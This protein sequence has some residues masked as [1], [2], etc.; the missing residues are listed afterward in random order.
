MERS[1]FLKSAFFITFSIIICKVI[2]LLYVIP[3][4]AMIG[5][6]GGALYSY[7]YSIYAVFLSLSTSG[8]P[9]AISKLISEYQALGYE[10]TKER[11]YKLGLLAIF[12]ISMFL[13]F[14][15][16]LSAPMLA[17]IIL[18]GT[19]GG[20]SVASVTTVIRIVST[21][22]WLVPLLAVLRGYFQGT[23]QMNVVALTNIIEQVVRVAVI[24]GGT[25]LT[26]R[27]F[28]AP[29]DQAVGFA[30]F[31]S[32]VGALVA[33]L[34]L[35]FVRRKQRRHMAV[36]SLPTERK[37]TNTYLIK[38]IIIYALPFLIIEGVQA[39]FSL[40]DTFTVI[41]TLVKLGFS[42]GQA[43]MVQS[44]M[45][46]WGS[47]LNMVIV[48][49][50]LGIS[51]SI[52]P[53]IAASYAKKERG[54]VNRHLHEAIIGLSLLILPA[55]LGMHF[56]SDS[57]WTL[58]YGH[59]AFASHVF[60]WFIFIA[61]SF[62][63]FSLL[64]TITQT[65]NQTKLVM[66]TLLF[67]LLF[68]ILMNIPAMYL[69]QQ[70]GVDAYYGPIMV[71]IIVQI[72]GSTFLLFS[73]SY[74]ANFQFSKTIYYWLKI[75]LCALIMYWSLKILGLFFPVVGQTRGSAFLIVCG[76]VMVGAFLYFLL[77]WKSGILKQVPLHK[78]VL[79]KK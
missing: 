14:V 21:S 77:V 58:F 55:A 8:I 20:N 1:G 22:L 79:K 68:K 57:I 9:I 46:T 72:V 28:H 10:E 13:F 7:A 17:K 75:L 4:Y 64:I 15:M 47:K 5:S 32:T 48:S 50:A 38:K 45:T 71:T 78:K 37:L 65:I 69:L 40:V 66:K 62:S 42:T 52:V 23:K 54:E 67:V 31:G 2:G 27:V 26:I 73:L 16:F 36:R 74:Q 59:D 49:L 44:I 25:Y 35:Y 76:Y 43:E 30:V 56:L 70:F 60:S 61:V 3:F 63:F 24:L 34:Y 19:T 12:I 18:G 39:L 29:V 51:V 6:K 53:Y 33:F 11:V 41:R